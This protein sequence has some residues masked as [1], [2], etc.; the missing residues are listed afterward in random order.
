V[1]AVHVMIDAIEFAEAALDAATT[2]EERAAAQDNINGVRWRLARILDACSFLMPPIHVCNGITALREL[3][4]AEVL[5]AIAERR[6]V[7]FRACAG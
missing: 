4:G 1:S 3:S 5:I 6:A 2:D 7:D